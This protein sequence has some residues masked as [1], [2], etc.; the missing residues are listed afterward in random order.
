MGRDVAVVG[1]FMFFAYT[2]IN[3]RYFVRI[4]IERDDLMLSLLT[5]RPSR[6]PFH[7]G[8]FN[9][10]NLPKEVTRRAAARRTQNIIG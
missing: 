3:G 7:A 8:V 2:F 10:K 9:D 1:T 4:T 6:A 5:S